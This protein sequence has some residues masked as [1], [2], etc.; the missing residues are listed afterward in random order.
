MKKM[1]LKT[2]VI[3]LVVILM[4]WISLI[5][6]GQNVEA[7]T[8]QPVALASPAILKVSPLNLQEMGKTLFLADD[9]TAVQATLIDTLEVQTVPA[10]AGIHFKLGKLSFVSGQDGTVRIPMNNS[11]NYS[12]AVDPTPANTDTSLYEF[13]CWSDGSKLDNRA[14]SITG[15]QVMQVGLSLYN[16]VG[17]NFKDSK[18]SP[19]DPARITLITMQ[20]ALGDTYSFPDGQPRWFLASVINRQANGLVQVNVQYSLTS[21]IVDGLNVADPSKGTFFAAPGISWPVSL[22]LYSVHIV[23]RDALFKNPVGSGVALE[24]PN[25]S[26]ETIPFGANQDV[27]IS[28]LEQGNYHVQVT[29]VSGISSYTPISLSQDQEVDLMLPTQLDIAA[30]FAAGILFALALLLVGRRWLYRPKRVA[31]EVNCTEADFK[32]SQYIWS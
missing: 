1:F 23:A 31:R 22:Q 21:V 12:L 18:G 7:R 32:N 6:P 2:L 24:Y 27:T 16:K 8:G 9:P 4:F 3:L 10:T 30:A 15:N 26:L 14:I 20:N 5:S 17:M 28:S 19:V 29:G 13:N 25:G 11:E